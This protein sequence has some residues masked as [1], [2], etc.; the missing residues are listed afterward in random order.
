MHSV[1]EGIRVLLKPQGVAVYEDPYLGDVIAKTSYDQIYDE[2]MYLFSLTSV[3]NMF[4]LHDMEL[5]DAVPQTTHGGSMRYFIGTKV[6]IRYR[7][8]PALAT[9]GSRAGIR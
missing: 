8:C 2:H 4:A 1:I 9:G 3:R 6:N 7:K 5:F